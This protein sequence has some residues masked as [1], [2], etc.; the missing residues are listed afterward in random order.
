[1][2]I[3]AARPLLP[4][5]AATAFAALTWGAASAGPTAE[6]GAEAEKLAEA[7]RNRAAWE[8]LVKAADAIWA[9]APLEFR[10]ILFV[11]AQPQGYGVYDPRPTAVF[12]AGE[13]LFV[14]GEPFG[15]GYGKEGDLEKIEFDVRLA[16]ATP[17]GKEVIPPRAGRLALTSRHRNKEFMLHFSY[18]PQGLA[19]G[20]YLLLAEF[21]D[22]STGKSVTA[23]L[24]FRIE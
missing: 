3:L 23:R 8:L 11:T 16:V 19:A 2:P 15:Y 14:Y 6:A 22:S 24:P 5:L 17:A 9:V 4:I 10:Q 21:R 7:G 1:M 13:T 12:K 20:D 18:T